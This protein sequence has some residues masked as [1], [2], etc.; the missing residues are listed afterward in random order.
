VTSATAEPRSDAPPGFHYRDEFVPFD[1]AGALVDAIAHLDFSPFELR[2]FVAKRRV[3]YF[4]ASYDSGDSAGPPIPAFL[5]RLRDRIATWA[6]VTGD[7]FVMALVNE[8]TP[9]TTIGWHRDAPQFGI[10]AGVSLLTA[11]RMKFRL[12]ERPGARRVPGARRL[13]SH[14]VSLQ[15]RS[16]YLMTGAARSA[17]E[18]HIPP[19]RALRYSITFRTRR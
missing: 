19:V 8:Y 11:C 12:Y 10:V 1:E 7:E 9:G 18:H 6:G 17:Y 14:E 2:G 16:A 13:T 3:A 4:G 15:P 5:E